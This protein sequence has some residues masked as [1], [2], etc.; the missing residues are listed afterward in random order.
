MVPRFAHSRYTGVKND[1][2]I[3]P[4][5]ASAKFGRRCGRSY[6]GQITLH[7]E[8]LHHSYEAVEG[9]P[10]PEEIEDS[11]QKMTIF[12]QQLREFEWGFTHEQL[13]SVFYPSLSITSDI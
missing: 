1:H 13:S 3:I 9:N 12:N 2:V 6:P 7:A 8:L 5:T 4:A 10:I 11:V